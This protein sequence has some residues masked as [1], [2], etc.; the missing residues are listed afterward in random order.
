MFNGN[1]KSIN[2]VYFINGLKGLKELFG[3]MIDKVR[4]FI[5]EYR[6]INPGERVLVAVSGGID[7]IVLLHILGC[8]DYNLERIVIYVH[9]GLR[10]EADE[11]ALW[12]QKIA[13]DMEIPCLIRHI[14]TKSVAAERGESIQMAARAE[15]YRVLTEAANEYGAT[16]IAL[17]HHADDQAET[18]LIRLLTG[19]GLDGLGGMEPVRGV[20]IRPLLGV[21][22]AQIAEYARENH[23]QWQEDRSN[24]DPHYLRNRLRLE[25]IPQLKSIQPR[26]VAHL[27]QLTI[28]AQEWQGWIRESMDAVVDKLGVEQDQT[29]IFW[30]YQIW[31]E[32][33][34]PLKRQVIKD[35]FYRLFP[36]R[37]L[38]HKH[39]TQI[40]ES[41]K[42]E[43]SGR[44]DQ[45]PGGGFIVVEGERMGIRV[46][47]EPISIG[48]L[49]IP[50]NIPGQTNWPGG[51]LQ[52]QWITPDELP[53]D[54]GSVSLYEAYFA[55]EVPCPRLFLRNR[56]PGDRIIAFDRSQPEKLKKLM[57]DE[58]VPREFRDRV[59]ILVDEDDRIWWAVGVRH[60]EVG[61]ISSHHQE[62]L[63]FR[64]N[65]V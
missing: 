30:S 53:K 14:D 27:N 16:R 5:Q 59:P 18:V 61:R 49:N 40:L 13:N 26:V 1:S 45:L 43:C 62:M 25:L 34:A 36:D 22:R 32:L 11:E 19:T 44:M 37:R 52:T 28:L 56:R 10:P 24:Q 50:V 9:H 4:Q 31:R 8:L 64:F 2:G 54:W 46:R 60:G 20:F 15:R 39:L 47:K 55:P 48:P 3:S 41:S 33:P 51:Y 42:T 57:I 17:G 12:L 58:K 29:G 7:S 65:K 35:A 6:L 23:L 38:D 21:T 63:Y